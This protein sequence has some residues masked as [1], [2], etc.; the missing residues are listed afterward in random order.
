MAYERLHWVESET[1]LSADNMNN[2]EDGIEELQA[3]KVDKVSGKA[4]SDNNYTTAEKTKLA[5][6]E[7]GA[8]VNVQ[9]D[10]SQSDS[11]ADDY[12]KNKPGEATTST[13]GLMSATDKSKLD[14]IATGAEVNQ[15][16]FS[17]VKVGST[18]LSAD[19]KTDTLNISGGNH[20]VIL[21]VASEDSLSI[22]TDLEN[23]T[24]SAAGLM[25]AT[26]K[27]KLNG[28]TTAAKNIMTEYHS[29]STSKTIGA[30]GAGTLGFVLDA[31]TVS[32]VVG[33]S[34][35]YMQSQG[36]TCKCCVGGWQLALNP[37]TNKVN[38]T[39]N[40]V[41]PTSSAIT[42]NLYGVRV[43]YKV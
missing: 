21:S 13:A 29:S 5:G 39:F 22:A 27:S 24:T 16:A 18:T 8:E 26:D 34:E 20:I 10:W 31:P 19:S 15:N 11:N 40:I 1:P 2:I 9:P 35:F 42:I 38:L 33:V 23:A 36:G 4:L 41:N 28:I 17:N 25:S 3:Q 43:S 32:S 12:I 37:N 30:N 7:A 6:I 14:G